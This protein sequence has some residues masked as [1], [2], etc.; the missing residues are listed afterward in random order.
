[1]DSVAD[2]VFYTTALIE[3]SGPNFGQIG[4]GFIMS[5]RHGDGRLVPILVTN[6]HVLEGSSSFTFHLAS[7]DENG[8]ASGRRASATVS[9]RELMTVGHPDAE[10]DVAAV[11]FQPILSRMEDNGQ[12]PIVRFITPELLLTQE[13]AE[14]L[15][16]I[17][18][19]T[20]IGYPD[21]LYDT[22][23]MLPIA[24]RGSTATPIANDYRGWSAFLIDASVYPGSSGSPVFI[25]DRGSYN[26]R[27]GTAIGTR[28]HLAG[29]VAAVHTRQ[30]GGRVTELPAA[31]IAEF[32]EVIGL[33]IVFKAGAIQETVDKLFER[34]GL[35]MTTVEPD[36][37]A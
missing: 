10:T 15:D 26:T 34:A 36:G 2:Q 12:E 17:E 29:I 37:L 14:R 18:D 11:L 20:F 23:S 21:G 6:K 27:E 22:H 16:S 13:Q 9:G 8:R 1:M 32:D 19:V 33:G 7:G 24:R 3:A 35:S 5:Y 31:S 28:V 25:L 30:V 4:T